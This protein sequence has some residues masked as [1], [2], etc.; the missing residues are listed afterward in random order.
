MPAQSLAAARR[1]RPLL[2]APEVSDDLRLIGPTRVFG[3]D[4]AIFDEGDGVDSVY[5]VVSGGVRALRLLADGRRQIIGFHL[6]GDIFGLELGE[7]R[8]GSAEA[9]GETT[10]LIARRASLG[11]EPGQAERLWRVSLAALE[12]SQDHVLT[13]GRRSAC[14][15][16]ASFLL[17]LAGRLGAGGHFELPM[18]RLDIADHLGLTIETVSRSLGQLQAGGLV[19]L[20]SCRRVRLPRPAALAALCQ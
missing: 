6:P 1:P 2:E 9:L 15:R 12:R 18:S 14:E 8:R 7:R 20:D 16:V 13:L 11:A 3:R 10:L 4:E 17:D 19:R 5:R